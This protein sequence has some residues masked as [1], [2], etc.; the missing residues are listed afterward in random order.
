[1]PVSNRPTR[2]VLAAALV[3]LILL[4][5][6]VPVGAT[7]GGSAYR[8]DIAPAGAAAG[9]SSELVITITQLS[10]SHAKKARSV[11][12]T[13]PD[14]ISITGATAKKGGTTLSVTSS[15]SVATVKD[16]PFT[17]GG[18]T[19][20]IKLQVAIPCGV[21]GTKAWTVVAR[22]SIDFSGGSALSQDPASSLTTSVSRCSLAFKDQPADAMRGKVITSE[23]ADPSGTPVKVR[24]LDG[25]GAPASRSGVTVSLAIASGT[26]ASG[27]TLG[28]TTSDAT[29]SNGV[30]TFAPTIDRSANGYRLVASASGI[31]DSD[32]SSAFDIDDVAVMCSGACSGTSSQGGTTATVNASASGGTL[33]FSLG[34]GNVDC[35]DKANL[36]YKSTSAPIEFNVTNG[37]GR[38]TVEIELARKDV[39]KPFLLYGVCFSSPESRFRNIFGKWIEPGEAGLLPPCLLTMRR[40]DQPCVVAT[41]LDRDRDVH[42]RFSVPPGDP[43]GRI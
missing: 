35:N 34:Q 6:T 28:G 13:A 27:A 33:T 17:G 10:G 8:A 32:R 31:I 42:V 37:T 12:V 40:S 9:A 7:G 36:W 39:T 1:M 20:T 41:W 25:N 29:N 4:I 21:G 15:A 2:S 26:G 24:L 38:T 43:R 11:R 14:G 5:G 22:S 23:A 18:Q 3:I 19:A 16:I 30:A